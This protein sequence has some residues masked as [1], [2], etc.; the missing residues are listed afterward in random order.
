MLS[1]SLRIFSLT[2]A[3]CYALA[4]EPWQNTSLPLIQRVHNL[5]SLLTLTEKVANLFSNNASG[6]ARIGLPPYRY[7]EE[8]MRGAV[9][10]GVAPRPL[11][12]GFPTL[13]ALASTFNVSLLADVATASAREIRAYYNIDRRTANLTTTANCYAPVVNLIRDPRFGRSAEMAIG[14]DPTLGRIYARAWTSAMRGSSRVETQK[15]V[16]S[17]CKHLGVYSG[18]ESGPVDRFS[19]NAVLTERTWRESFLPAFRGSAEGGTDAF[20]CSYSSVTLSDEPDKL[21]ST[22]DCASSYLLNTVVRGE[23]NWTGFVT[24]DAMA[25]SKIY[26]THHFVNSSAAA[27]AAALLAGCDL[28]LVCCGEEPIYPSLVESVANGLVPEAAIDTALLR[29]LT[30]RFAV[31]DLDPPSDSPYAGLN[32]SDIY[33]ASSLQ[34]AREAASAAVVLLAQAATNSLPWLPSTLSQ[35]SFCVVGP[36]ANATQDFMGGYSSVPRP[37]DIVSPYEAFS[38]ALT[39]TAASIRYIAGCKKPVSVTCA[40]LENTLQT[41]LKTC[42]AIVAVLGTS[43]I[44][45]VTKPN[46]SRESEGTDREN[47]MLAG[48]QGKLLSVLLAAGKPLAVVIASGGMVNLGPAALDTRASLLSAPFGGQWAGDAI[49]AVVLG[50]ENPSG[51]LTQSWYTTAALSRMGSITNYSMIGRTYRFAPE[52]DVVFSFGHGLSFSSFVY[53]NL[54]LSAASPVPCDIITV[55]ATITN[56]RGGAGIEVPQLYLSFASASVPTPRLALVNFERIL[57]APNETKEIELTIAPEDN[58]VLRNVD[59]IPVIEP[60]VRTLWLG[61]SSNSR[62]AGVTGS[63][64][65]VGATTPLSA[66]GSTQGSASTSTTHADPH[67]NIAHVWPQ[68]LLSARGGAARWAKDKEKE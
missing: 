25:V 15:L 50:A 37:G 26:S 32:E 7:D 63:Y 39:G 12:T 45:P 23:W 44:A 19:F 20:M 29:V 60:G 56:T 65:V 59:F 5:V 2:F 55:R 53:T 64:N 40:S 67:E 9:T 30:A 11:G 10:S 3:S 43:A 6:A 24:S 36:L 61:A 18:P 66:C 62:S 16:S 49:A 52:E 27:A 46:N 4:L 14:E 13:L 35:R 58:S 47:V 54:S 21:N 31:G 28:E 68:P 51:R 48:M 42:D 17:V 8:C 22:P 41:E 57:L 34:L 1:L 33:S 38:R